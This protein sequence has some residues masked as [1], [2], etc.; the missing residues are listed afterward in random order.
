MTVVSAFDDPLAGGAAGDDADVVGP[1]HDRPDTGPARIVADGSPIARKPELAVTDTQMIAQPPAAPGARTA[2]PVSDASA[3]M[4]RKMRAPTVCV[5]MAY[6]ATRMM[7]CMR[8]V[9]AMKR[10]VM[11]EGTRIGVG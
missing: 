10:K 3:P 1:H 7:A 4:A 2:A 11:S 6:E 5:R 8:V 9:C